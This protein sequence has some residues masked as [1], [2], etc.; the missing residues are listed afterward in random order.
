MRAYEKRGKK[1]SEGTPDPLMNA[2]DGLGHVQKIEMIDGYNNLKS[3]LSD[4]LRKHAEA[5]AVVTAED[6]QNF[7]KG[8]KE[9]QSKKAAAVPGF[10]C[11]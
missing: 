11:R 6:V 3:C 4:F 5:K 7:F 9:M 10:F 2:L 1:K 8:M